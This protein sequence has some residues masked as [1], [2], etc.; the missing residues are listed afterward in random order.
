M[1]YLLCV[2]DWA[3]DFYNAIHLIFIRILKKQVVIII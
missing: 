1:K 3:G 2:K